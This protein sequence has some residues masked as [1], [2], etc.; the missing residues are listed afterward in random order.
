MRA[1]YPYYYHH[2]GDYNYKCMLCTCCL[3]IGDAFE[4]CIAIA[5]EAAS[6]VNAQTTYRVIATG[7][8]AVRG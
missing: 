1:I 4:V 6:N 3:S 2:V 8:M 7:A 5:T